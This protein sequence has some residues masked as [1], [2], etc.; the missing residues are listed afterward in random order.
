MG[1]LQFSSNL[2]EHQSPFIPSFCDDLRT[3]NIHET[4]PPFWLVKSS[5]VFFKQCRKELIQCK[6]RK[7]TK[8][9]DWSMI[10]ETPD[11]QSNLLFSNQMH[12]LDGAIDGAI[13]PWLRDTRAFLL[14]N[15][16]KIFSMAAV[17]VVKLW[18]EKSRS[19]VFQLNCVHNKMLKY[20]WLLTALIYNGNRA[21]WSPI[22]SVIIHSA[23]TLFW[24]VESLQRIFEISAREV[25]CRLYNNHVKVTC[26]V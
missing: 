4:I 13:F 7:Q 15:R 5:A 12:A 3:N 22:W 2:L 8:H 23:L 16:L 9:S 17:G 25:T 14:L 20:Y 10:R 21:E 18:H 6:K 19:S 1:T 26:H 11:G 24:L